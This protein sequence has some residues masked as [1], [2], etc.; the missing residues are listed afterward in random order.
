[1]SL[2]TDSLAG[3]AR[4]AAR[5]LVGEIAR[6]IISP[7]QQAQEPSTD[8]WRVRLSLA[9]GATYLYKDNTNPLLAPLRNTE[10]VIFPYTPTITVAY[11]ANYNDTEIVHSNYKIYQY[12]N[13]S[14]DNITITCDFTAQDTYE[15]NYMLAV[16]HFFRSATKMFYGQDQNPLAGTPPPLCFLYGLGAYQFDKHPLVISNFTYTLPNDVDY[17]R[18]GIT[19]SPAGVLSP[20]QDEDKDPPN[21]LERIGNIG[22]I[23]RLAGRILPGGNPVPPV[24]SPPTSGSGEGTYVPTKITMTITALPVVSRNEISNNFSVKDY[25]TGK[26]LRGSIRNG[27]GM[28]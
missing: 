8:D 26:L 10:G 4:N 22:S 16:I 1:M 20:S 17:I 23:I 19:S 14:V 12:K 15:A 25:A 9:P 7:T 28:W 6:T 3:L 24:F 18:A 13:S 11:N 2:L 27:G 5:G 21:L